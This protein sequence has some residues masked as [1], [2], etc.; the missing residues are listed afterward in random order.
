MLL[1]VFVDGVDRAEVEEETQP[2]RHGADQ[3]DGGFEVNCIVCL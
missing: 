3:Q 2:P 1:R